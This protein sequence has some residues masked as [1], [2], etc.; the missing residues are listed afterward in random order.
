MRVLSDVEVQQFIRD[1]FVRIDQVF[2]LELADEGRV[3]L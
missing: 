2:P 1:G 3:I